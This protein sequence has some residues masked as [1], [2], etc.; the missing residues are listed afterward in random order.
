[1]MSPTQTILVPSVACFTSR[2]DTI[3]FVIRIFV[4]FCWW[5][6]K[7][8]PEWPPGR[9]SHPAVIVSGGL[10]LPGRSALGTAHT[11][12]DDLALDAAL[13]AVV[14]PVELLDFQ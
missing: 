1:M 5:F 14:E 11:V 7:S 13:R 4:P 10:V 8:G 9:D 6:G 12:D 3:S 2:S